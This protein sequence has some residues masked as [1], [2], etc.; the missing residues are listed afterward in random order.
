VLLLKSG[1]ILLDREPD[2][3]DPGEAG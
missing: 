2:G 3:V 1:R